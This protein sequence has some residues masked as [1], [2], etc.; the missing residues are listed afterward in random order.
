MIGLPLGGD[1]DAVCRQ[2]RAAALGALVHQH[3]HIADVLLV[4]LFTA[5]DQLQEPVDGPHCPR[6]IFGIAF[7]LKVA[8]RLTTSTR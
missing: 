5:V 4:E 7:H 1:A 6:Y 2:L 3:Q 8:A